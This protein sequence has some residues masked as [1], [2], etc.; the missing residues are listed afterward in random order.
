MEEEEESPAVSASPAVSRSS[1]GSGGH[2][3]ARQGK[4]SKVATYPLRQPHLMYVSEEP[5]EEVTAR[6]WAQTRGLV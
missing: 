3:P 2:R 5:G 1:P 4:R 6:G